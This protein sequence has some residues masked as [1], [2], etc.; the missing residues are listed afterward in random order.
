MKKLCLVAIPL[1]LSVTCLWATDFKARDYLTISSG[2][3]LK[4]DLITAGK[5]IKIEGEVV[6]DVLSGC[7]NLNISGT[8]GNSV[9]DFS[10][11]LEISGEVRGSVASFCQNANIFGTIKRNLTLFAQRT[12]IG[13]DAVIEG[14]FTAFCGEMD[15]EGTVKKG[16]VLRCGE[17]VISGKIDGD[18]D[19]EGERLVIMEGAVING[20]LKYKTYK[21]A[22]IS[23]QAQITGETKWTPRVKKE[24]KTGAYRN[25]S[26]FNLGLFFGSLLTGVVLIAVFRRK[27]DRAREAVNKSVLKSLGVGFVAAICVPIAALILLVTVIGIPLSI[28]TILAYLVTFYV[29]KLVFGTALGVWVFKIFKKNSPAS[30]IWCFIVGYTTFWIVTGFPYLGTLVYWLAYFIG[31]GAIITA[32]K[33]RATAPALPGQPSATSGS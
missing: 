31:L 11:N 20:S 27:W 8:V 22:K 12:Y 28:L 26:L 16:I 3:V 1:I 4:D 14:Q 5:D 32:I 10:Q 2:Q 13:R 24:K 15:L 9:Y 21:E 6:G 25:L 7:R 18:V 30:L 23:P 33:D 19:M 17:A 29:A